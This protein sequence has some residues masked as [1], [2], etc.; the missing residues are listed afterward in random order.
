MLKA[1][2]F[3]LDDT[4]FD[5]RHSSRAALTLLQKE[6]A[7]ELGGVPLDELA[8]AT[9]D[10]LNSVHHEVLAGTILPDEARIKRFRMLLGKY[11]LN[12]SVERTQAIAEMYR[13]EYQASRRAAPGA[14]RVLQA[15]QSRGIKTGVVSNNLV[16]EQMDKLQHC[17]LLDVLDSITISEEAG[18]TKP[19]ARIFQIALERLECTPE[20]A[21]MIG[22]SWENDIVGAR[23]VGITA[24]WYNGYLLKSPDKNVPEIVSFEDSNALL[25][26]LF[27]I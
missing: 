23:A 20:E 19:D 16:S 14:R 7:G 3:D 24:I 6:F 18:F 21:N 1:V 15:I 22:D 12:P 4:L 10:I 2:L 13:A 5:H 8:T 11:G 25:R 17:E 27:S 9:L 26:L